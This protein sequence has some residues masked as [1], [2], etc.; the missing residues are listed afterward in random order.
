MPSEPTY[1]RHQR[2]AQ[3]KSPKAEAQRRTAQRAVDVV[4]MSLASCGARISADTGNIQLYRVGMF[5][6]GA[7]CH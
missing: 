3:R 6:G 7:V 2:R 1:H 4:S 5:R